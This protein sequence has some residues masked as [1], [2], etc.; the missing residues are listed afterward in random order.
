[1]LPLFQYVVMDRSGTSVRFARRRRGAKPLAVAQR[2]SSVGKDCFGV[3]AAV[4]CG[5]RNLQMDLFA[6]VNGVRLSYR[7]SEARVCVQLRQGLCFPSPCFWYLYG[8]TR[9]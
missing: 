5:Q 7:C 8:V 2:Q 4:C 1:M 3:P 6:S 9:M